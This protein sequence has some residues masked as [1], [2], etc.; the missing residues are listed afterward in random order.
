ML[1]LLGC[2]SEQNLVLKNAN[3][4]MIY[5]DWELNI[6]IAKGGEDETIDH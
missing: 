6:M 1:E 5:K 2:G 3:Y 4:G